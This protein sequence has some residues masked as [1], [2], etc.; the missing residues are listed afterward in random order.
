MPFYRHSFLIL[1]AAFLS[2]CDS[3]H[4]PPPPPP[5]EYRFTEIFTLPAMPVEDQGRSGTCWCFSTSSFLESE[6]L[7]LTGDSVDLSE[8]YFVQNAYLLKGQ[9]FILRQGTSRF[10]EGG[11]NHDPLFSMPVLGMMPES[12]YLGKNVGDS[13]FDHSKMYPELLDSM[14][15]WADPGK[16]RTA[17]WKLGLP[18]ILEKYMGKAPET[19]DYKGTKYSPSSFMAHHGI[20]PRDYVNI[21][22]FIHHPFY[23]PF[24]LE[25]PANHLNGEFYNLPLDEYMAVINYALDSGFTLALD[26]DAIEPGFSPQYGVAMVAADPKNAETVAWKVQPEMADISQQYRQEEFENL[27]TVDD[28]NMHIVGKVKDQHGKV[29]FKVKNSWG[30]KSCIN[31]FMY[32][33]QPYIRLK[34]IYV[35]LHKNGLPADIRAKLGL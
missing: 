30:E 5:S 22:S 10:T 11:S 34:S 27:R 23:K 12:A 35:M 21:T 7:R 32:M 1:A 14:Q 3:N 15:I 19:F 31:G 28:H 6:I 9:N 17:A 16:K 20:Q 24:I 25:I 18:A 2:A 33:S 8:M 29:Y 4:E 13:V 26:T